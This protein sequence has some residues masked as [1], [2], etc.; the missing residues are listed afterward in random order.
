MAIAKTRPTGNADSTA[1]VTPSRTGTYAEAYCIPVYPPRWTLAD[2][3]SY[4][5][6]SNATDDTQITAHAAPAIVDTDTKPI[7]H[8][9]NGGTKDVYLDFIS[10]YSIVA[11]ASATRVFFD[12]YVDAKGSTNKSSG[13]TVATVVNNVRN[14]SSN[15][16]GLIITAGAVVAAPVSSRKVGHA[17]IRPAIGIALDQY[18]FSFGN[19]MTMAQGAF[20]QA[21]VQSTFTAMPPVVVAPGGNFCFVQI[22]PSG[23]GTAMTF[24]YQMGW[25]ER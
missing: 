22:S 25:A 15:T 18:H 3:G 7:I 11:N 20:V 17:M 24:E 19:G 6:A 10:I 21:T 1:I 23:A 9:Y 13:G 4:Y 5:T 14:N 8:F 16:T 12:A 2:E